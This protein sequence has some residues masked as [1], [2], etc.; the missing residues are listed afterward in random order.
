[1]SG[2]Q[3]GRK[4]ITFCLPSAPLTAAF[5]IPPP[6]RDAGRGKD[7]IWTGGRCRLLGGGSGVRESL[8]YDMMKSE[9]VTRSEKEMEVEGEVRRIGR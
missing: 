1:M 7:I 8:Q 5:N 3:A 4:R 6:H 9:S 2:W